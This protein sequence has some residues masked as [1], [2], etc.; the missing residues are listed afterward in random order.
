M[1]FI[2]LSILWIIFFSVYGI[3]LKIITFIKSFP[4]P[5]G[6]GARGGGTT[7]WVDPLPEIPDGMRHQF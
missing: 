5:R 7:Y 2:I 3:I 6:G 4:S 1:S